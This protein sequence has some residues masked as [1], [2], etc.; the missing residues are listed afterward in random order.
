MQLLLTL[1]YGLLVALW[2]TVG[3]IAAVYFVSLAGY[4]LEEWAFRWIGWLFSIPV[5]AWLMPRTGRPA[6]H[7]LGMVVPLL[8]IYLGWTT[9]WRVAGQKQ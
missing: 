6:W 1:G 5:F 8:N 7:S 2:N 3:A 9:L 4:E